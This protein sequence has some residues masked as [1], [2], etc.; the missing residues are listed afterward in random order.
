MPP[1]AG[2]GAPGRPARWGRTSRAGA[3][4][5]GWRGRCRRRAPAAAAARPATAC[6][7]GQDQPVVAAAHQLAVGRQVRQQRHAAVGHGLQHR[8]RHRIAA[9]QAQVPARAGVVAGLR[10]RVEPADEAHLVLQAQRCAPAPAARRAA[11]RRWPPPAA[12]RARPRRWRQSRRSRAAAHRSAP[13][14]GWRRTAHRPCAPAA[15]AA[16]PG[17]RESTSPRPRPARACAA[18]CAASRWC[19]ARRRAARGASASASSALRCGV[20][21]MSLAP[22]RAD[23]PARRAQ[24]RGRQPGQRAVRGEVVRMHPVGPHAAQPV[25]QAAAACAAAPTLP[26]PA[27]GPRAQ[28]QA[29]LG[30]Q[31]RV[32]AGQEAAARRRPQLHAAAPARAP[33]SAGAGF[34]RRPTAPGASTLMV[35]QAP[36]PGVVV[37]AQFGVALQQ[38][39]V[40]LA[41]VAHHLRRAAVEHGEVGELAAHH[42]AGAHQRAAAERACRPRSALCGPMKL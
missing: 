35:R 29:A 5:R 33:T 42:A 4:S 2:A 28:R 10:G 36:G 30:R 25:R 18:P 31:Q 6:A 11:S 14:R 37:R 38:R 8:H 20:T 15:A 17:R 1:A 7:V 24:H 3:P 13:G 23:Q 39:L 32:E 22:G 34:R 27:L 16:S 12:P 19:S 41:R 21:R 40:A 9:R 26:P